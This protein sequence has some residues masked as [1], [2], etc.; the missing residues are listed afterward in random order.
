MP[1]SSTLFPGT[2][3]QFFAA[4]VAV[5]AVSVFGLGAQAQV[6]GSYDNFD[7]FNDTGTEAEGFEID[8]EDVASTDLTREFP[9]NFAQPWLIR[10]GLPTV[11]SYDWTSASPDTAH[12]YDAGHKGVLIT[13]AATLQGGK[14]VA[15]QGANPQAPGV[16]G[17]GT[18]YN[19][20]PTA[21]SGESCWWWGLGAT[22]P[23]T[24]CEHFGISF[25]PG[26][27]PGK[28]TYHWK[29]PDPTNTVLIN[30]ALEASIPPSPTLTP[31]AGGPAVVR[32][33]A[34][35]PDDFGGNPGAPQ[36]QEPQFGD[37]YWLQVTSFYGK[38]AALLDQLQIHLLKKVKG[39][40]K[41]VSWILVQR[42]PG[43]GA[44]AGA[45]EREDDEQDNIPAGNVQ[46][47]KQYQ[48]YKFGGAY[49]SETHEVLCDAFYATA[50]NAANGGPTVQTDCTNAA[51][52]TAP[53]MGTYYTIDDG[54]GAVVKVPKGNLG[55]YVGAHLNA[56][57]VQ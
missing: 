42:P 4:S 33:V 14:W 27:A 29:I 53:Y 11:T 48:Y 47:T 39:V 20:H 38:N 9:S 22:Y 56:Y 40:K 7:C 41:T 31:V 1:L 26:V 35:A 51:G 5:L 2:G 15:P 36:E 3:R 34:R 44:L 8:V 46:V 37:A 6:I 50:A 21:T 28:I 45:G 24:G 25:G 19:P 23:D 52:N 43:V 10:Y 54:S 18:P 57:N 13:Y 16:A 12:A 30:A 49:D 32:V 55:T 17:N